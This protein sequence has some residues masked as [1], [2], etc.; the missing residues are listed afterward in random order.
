MLW[1]RGVV[2]NL[3]WQ[4]RILAPFK[5]LFRGDRKMTSRSAH[6]ISK[7]L[8]C[9]LGLK[10]RE[11]FCM[12]SREKVVG[13]LGHLLGVWSVTH[14]R[15]PDPG[16]W[17]LHLSSAFSA[18]RAAGP[19]CLSASAVAGTMLTPEPCN[20][21]EGDSLLLPSK[22]RKADTAERVAW[23]PEVITLPSS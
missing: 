12:V 7:R 20:S 4:G 14:S 21:L 23:S 16:S 11:E 6:M 22:V 2:T 18:P 1:E 13:N 15:L 19:A 17:N 5:G 8:Q 9:E 3:T 10:E